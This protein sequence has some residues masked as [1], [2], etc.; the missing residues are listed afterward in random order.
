MGHRD[1][2]RLTDREARPSKMVLNCLQRRARDLLRQLPPYKW[3]DGPSQPNERLRAYSE[4]GPYFSDCRPSWGWSAILKPRGLSEH[5]FTDA[6]IPS[7]L[8][9]F[10]SQHAGRWEI[11]RPLGNLDSSE[12]INAYWQSFP[13]QQPATFPAANP[14][15]PHAPSTNSELPIVFLTSHSEIWTDN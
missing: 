4:N 13:M 7:L 12:R 3:T 14:K 1:Y 6:E 2:N 11:G 9:Q 15:I 8:P 5:L 10:G